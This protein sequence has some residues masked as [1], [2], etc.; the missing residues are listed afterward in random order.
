MTGGLHAAGN[1]MSSFATRHDVISHN[2]ANVSTP[3]FA[4]EDTY[5]ARAAKVEESPFDPPEVRTRT[6]FTPGPPTL[7]NN[8]LDLSLQGSGFFTLI[9]DA[10]ERYSRNLSLRVDAEGFLRD[11]AGHAVLGENGLMHV[12]EGTPS[13]ET[14]GTVLVDGAPLDRLKLTT[15]AHGDDLEREAAGLYALQKGHAPDPKA[16][17]PL[18]QSGQIEGSGVQAVPELVNMIEALRA[19]EAAAAAVRAT[20]ATLDKA[21]NEIARV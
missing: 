13:V 14:D 12:G 5:L 21:V 16:E 7:T 4:R 19:Y 1:A 20:D 6:Q 15:F 9:T 2:L 11:D 18:V 17:R 3:G 10:G 8:P